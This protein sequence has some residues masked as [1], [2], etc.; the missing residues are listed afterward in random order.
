MAVP[1]AALTALP[2]FRSAPS[3]GRELRNAHLDQI[4]PGL[5]VRVDTG[6]PPARGGSRLLGADQGPWNE[7]VAKGE[8]RMKEPVDASTASPVIQSSLPG[9]VHDEAHMI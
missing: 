5:P 4:V 8:V 2:T 6:L 7:A 1:Q 9:P 3:W